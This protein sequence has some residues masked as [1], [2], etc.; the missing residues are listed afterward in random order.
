MPISM[1]VNEYRKKTGG[2]QRI[3][4]IRGELMKSSHNKYAL[5]FIGPSSRMFFNPPHFPFPITP[6]LP[7]PPPFLSGMHSAAQ[8]RG[9]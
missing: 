9:G 6:P 7:P 2:D 3:G 8:G 4:K 1:Q 5:I